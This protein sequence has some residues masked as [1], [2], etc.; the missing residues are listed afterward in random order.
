MIFAKALLQTGPWSGW[1]LAEKGKRGD[2][3]LLKSPI[4]IP[5]FSLPEFRES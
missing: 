4:L 1:K 3:V 2:G 5:A